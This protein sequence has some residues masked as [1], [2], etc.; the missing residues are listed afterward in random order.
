MPT[1]FVVCEGKHASLDVRLLDHVLA[2]KHYLPIRVIPGG[3]SPSISSRIS[4]AIPTR[5]VSEVFLGILAYASGWYT[6]GLV[7][8]GT[9]IVRSWYEEQTNSESET[10]A[11]AVQD[12]DYQPLAKVDLLWQDPTE[13][14][15]LW[16]FHEI[17][18]SLLTPWVIHDAF[19]EYRRTLNLSWVQNLSTTESE[20][21]A[22]LHS[23]AAR[24]YN[25]HIGK[26]LCY[27]LRSHK[28][29]IGPTEINIPGGIDP[30]VGTEIEWQN[31]IASMIGKMH[32]ACH[33]IV[34]HPAFQRVNVIQTW[35][36]LEQQ[37]RDPAFLQSGQF[38]RDLNGKLLLNLLWQHLRQD[39]RYPGN[40]K[41]FIEDLVQSFFRLYEPNSAFVI[42]E[43]E[44]LVQRIRALLVTPSTS[45]Q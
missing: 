25:D 17:E 35:T 10:I 1:V 13:R 43:F 29:T 24:L 20:I 42:A 9:R 27:E 34:V 22:V 44:D 19:E 15:L 4:A 36:R 18:N 12:R 6:I 30:L 37:V 21:E 5:S 23:Q 11:V 33:A 39:C 41:D 28:T 14:C 31:A 26:T 16:R 32:S 40:K 3:S 45:A 2:Q 8:R 7:I 38:R